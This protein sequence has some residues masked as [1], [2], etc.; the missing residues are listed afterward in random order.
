MRLDY[1]ITGYLIAVG[2][3]VLALAAVAMVVYVIYYYVFAGLLAR[4]TTVPAEILRKKQTTSGEVSAAFVELLSSD[5]FS[6]GPPEERATGYDYYIVFGVYGKEREFA[7]P[8]EVYGSVMEGDS[9]WLTHRGNIFLR[10]FPAD[11]ELDS[12]AGRAQI[13]KVQR[14]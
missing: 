8:E 12:S 3:I 11:A 9:G 7:V 10:F 6:V 13:R 5:G 14:H 4:T 1:H 2:A